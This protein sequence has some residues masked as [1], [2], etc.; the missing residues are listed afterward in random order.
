VDYYLFLAVKSGLLRLSRARWPSL[1]APNIYKQS[2][3][4]R[5]IE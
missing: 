5:F 3:E 4:L 1:L 2:K